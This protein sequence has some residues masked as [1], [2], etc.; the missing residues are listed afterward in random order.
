MDTIQSSNMDPPIGITTE[1]RPDSI[2]SIPEIRSPH[3]SS[4]TITGANCSFVAEDQAWFRNCNFR[5]ESDNSSIHI[6]KNVIFSGSIFLKGTRP[7]RVFIGPGTSC[8]QA[9][10]ICGEGSNVTIGADCML[11]WAIE[12][13]STDSHAIFDL[14]TGERVNP[15]EDIVIGDHVWIAAKTTLLKGTTIS[16]GSVVG[17]GTFTSTAYPEP[18]VVIAG[19]PGRVV[20]RNIRW[21]RPLLG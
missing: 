7:N 2:V 6:S 1:I 20:R 11:A 15:S 9:T 10:I 17:M 8:G 5:I 13:R 19:N 12:I 21:E 18:N 16:N 3:N 14:E 4:L